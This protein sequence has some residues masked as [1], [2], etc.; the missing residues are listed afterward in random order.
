MKIIYVILF[1]CFLKYG[2]S[3]Q[4]QQDVE[5]IKKLTVSIQTGINE[6]KPQLI[7]DTFIH[8]TALIYF[9]YTGISSGLYSEKLNTAKGLS[10]F[11]KNSKNNLHQ[12][13][14]NIKIDFRTEGIAIVSADYFVK[15]N[16]KRSHKGKE[17]YSA[18][19][20]TKGWKFTSLTFTT[21]S[22][23]E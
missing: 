10:N 17:Y 16:D 20:T 4:N 15:I 12:Y 11:V 14:E 3:Q 22:W 19:K 21:K 1:F 9:T 5:S 18:L 7:L 8:P 13:Y 23:K 2:F 6:K